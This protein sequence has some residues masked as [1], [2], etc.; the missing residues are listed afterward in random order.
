MAT[1]I[2]SWHAFLDVLLMRRH[3][4]AFSYGIKQVARTASR[5]PIKGSPILWVLKITRF[6][7]VCPS[8]REE[9]ADIVMSS[10]AASVIEVRS[11]N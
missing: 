4:E 10:L 7:W 11:A 2:F 9:I 1:L 6:M 3:S 8:I 5:T